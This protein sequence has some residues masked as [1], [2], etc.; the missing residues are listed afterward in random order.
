MPETREEAVRDARRAGIRPAPDT[1]VIPPDDPEGLEPP[2]A[3]TGGVADMNPAPLEA[4]RPPMMTSGMPDYP[5][6][7]RRSSRG[8]WI[9][10]SVIAVLLIVGVLVSL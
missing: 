10:A 8:L 5:A 3:P 2:I 7:P 4:E 6:S 9:G 1:D